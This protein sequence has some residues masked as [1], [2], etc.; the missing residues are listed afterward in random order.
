MFKAGS[1]VVLSLAALLSNAQQKVSK[2]KAPA[3]AENTL[4]WKIDG[5]GLT[6]P[7]YL[8]GTIHMICKDDAL[9]SDSMKA[10]IAACDAVYFEMDLDNIFEMM[11][12]LNKLKMR[13][14][15]TLKDLLEPEA[16]LR[17][18]T[19]FEKKST[20]LPFSI[21]ETYKPIMASS[22]LSE[23]EMPCDGAVSMEQLIM[24]EAKKK[25]KKIKG[26][27]TMSEQSGFLDSIPYKY[28]AA[29]LLKYVDSA[30]TGDNDN[31]LMDALF[32]AYREQDLNK[33]ESLM[34]DGEA[35]M[36]QYA[37]IL[38]YKRNARWA[39]ML[40]T[41]MGG[42]MLLIAVGAGHLPGEKGVI[43]LLRKAGYSVTPVPNKPTV[44][45]I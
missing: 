14:D 39:N 43:S 42:K 15:T 19:F 7:S 16:Y 18:K 24:L 13:G 31:A 28:Q 17:V 4:L 38:L 41:L 27:E 12:G 20:L 29:E 34:V 35:G 40:K 9:L 3:N 11:T 45:E 8:F 2:K 22:L 5:N 32:A 33:L 1:L 23:E 6:R 37:D 26:L 25:G 10:A 44:R 21:L 30:A 36:N